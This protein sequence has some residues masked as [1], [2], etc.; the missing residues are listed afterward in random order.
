MKNSAGLLDERKIRKITGTAD[1]VAKASF[2]KDA[3]RKVLDR[4]GIGL[5]NI[6]DMVSRYNGAMKM[7]IRDGIFQISVLV[8]LADDS[9]EN[10]KR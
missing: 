5:S 9:I 3:G 6:R 1:S 10:G 2:R 7:D 4:E 8:P